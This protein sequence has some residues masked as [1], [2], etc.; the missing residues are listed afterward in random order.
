M[1]NNI[2]KL[3]LKSGHYLLCKN[4]N[5]YTLTTNDE[6]CDLCVS[7]KRKEKINSILKS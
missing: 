5:M 6:L 1:K 2:K 7:I 3:I 4:C